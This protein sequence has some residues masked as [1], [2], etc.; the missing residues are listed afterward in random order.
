M[1]KRA[2]EKKKRQW[3]EEFQYLGSDYEGLLLIE[4]LAED[5]FNSGAL[6]EE[7]GT[8]VLDKLALDD[9]SKLK[10]CRSKANPKAW[11]ITIIKNLLE[12]FAR[13]TNGRQRPPSWLKDCGTLWIDIWKAICLERFPVPS[14]L[15]RYENNRSIELSTVEN[16]I[17][18][19]KEREPNCGLKK[20][21]ALRVS[22]FTAIENEISA[23][24]SSDYK[25][26]PAELIMYDVDVAEGAPLAIRESMV[27]PAFSDQYRTEA[28]L[29]LM[30][31]VLTE[32]EGTGDTFSLD[33][34]RSALNLAEA[35]NDKFN[36]IRETLC[37]TDEEIVLLRMIY[38]DGYT[39]KR[40]AEI[41]NISR[42][43]AISLQKKCLARIRQV[44]SEIELDFESLLEK[45]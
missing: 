27:S 8:Y 19:I 32:P 23:N 3:P 7:A 39:L 2:K 34:V 13:K 36:H 24:G 10:S 4:S 21:E 1:T 41:L 43:L 33:R 6:A 5:R 42:T 22:D 17:R 35:N 29:L 18:T 28:M 20:Y 9:W 11:L 14:V 44:V 16:A 25:D 40:V 15:L 30:I 38:F 37:L 45:I 31:R 26:D 12:D